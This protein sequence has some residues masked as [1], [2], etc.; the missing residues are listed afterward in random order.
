MENLPQWMK[1]L[2]H[3]KNNEQF[4]Q[5]CHDYFKLAT[6]RVMQVIRKDYQVP[7]E[8]IATLTLAIFARF[9]NEGCYAIGAF[10][11]NGMK[12]EEILSQ[13]Q[14]LTLLLVLQGS[15]LEPLD[16]DDIETEIEKSLQNFREFITKNA[17]DFYVKEEK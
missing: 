16:R 17:S 8:D 7:P 2:S 11:K 5:L 13:K 15:P 12:L 3:E 9:L 1:N 4:S 14:L 10:I 6:M